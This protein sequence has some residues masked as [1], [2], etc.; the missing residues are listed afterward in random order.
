MNNQEFNDIAPFDDGPD[1]HQHIERLVA[2]PQ[3]EHAVKWVLP[4]VDYHEFSKKLLDCHTQQEFQH[5]IMLPFLANL[6]AKTTQGVTLTGI[7]NY[8]PDKSY[9]LISNHRDIVLDASF[10]N[11]G[12]VR[13]GRQTCE[14]A[15][16]NNLPDAGQ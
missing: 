5:R 16:G 3:F 14:V 10:L 9:V 6:E 11:L 8:E 12:M 7:E 1:F 4:G 2:E 13:G 15:I